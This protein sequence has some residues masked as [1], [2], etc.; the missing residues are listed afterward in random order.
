DSIEIARERSKLKFRAR[1][2]LG[3]P[4]LAF[5]QTFILEV[6]ATLMLWR[7][8]FRCVRGM[9]G[10][11]CP[12]EHPVERAAALHAFVVPEGWVARPKPW[13]RHDAA[14]KPAAPSRNPYA[15]RT[16]VDVEARLS[17][18]KTADPPL[19]AG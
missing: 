5:V 9:L 8:T 7:F 18:T 11:S 16:S 4:F 14:R 6:L 10:N 3:N 17:P 1:A 12:A 2:L 13:Q 19:G 15:A